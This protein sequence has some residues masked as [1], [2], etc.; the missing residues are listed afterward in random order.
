MCC[1]AQKDNRNNALTWQSTSCSGDISIPCPGQGINPTCADYVPGF[2]GFP[3]IP[4]I[5]VFVGGTVKQNGLCFEPTLNSGAST[6]LLTLAS[7]MAGKTD[8]LFV[9]DANTREIKQQGRC[10]DVLG[11]NAYATAQLTS[12]TRS[13]R[14]NWFYSKESKQLTSGSRSGGL[15]LTTGANPTLIGAVG[16]IACNGSPN[17]E[18]V[19]GADVLLPPPLRTRWCNYDLG[20]QDGGSLAFSD[21][22][23]SSSADGTPASDGRLNNAKAWCSGRNGQNGFLQVNLPEAKIITAI[24]VQGYAD[25]MGKHYFVKTF[26][27]TTSYD[28]TNFIDYPLNLSTNLVDGKETRLVDLRPPVAGTFIRIV[29]VSSVGNA[30]IRVEFRGC[31]DYRGSQG[32]QGATGATGPSN[33][34]GQQGQV[35]RVGDQGPKGDVGSKGEL[36]PIGEQGAQGIPGSKGQQG[37]PG[38]AGAAGTGGPSGDPGVEGDKGSAGIRGSTGPQGRTGMTGPSGAPGIEGATGIDGVPG[39]QGPRGKDG[40]EG[41]DGHNGLPGPRGLPGNPGVTGDKGPKGPQGPPGEQG[42]MGRNGLDG[43]SGPPGVDGTPDS[44]AVLTRA[45]NLLDLVSSLEKKFKKYKCSLK[46]YRS[47]PDCAT[48]APEAPIDQAATKVEKVLALDLIKEHL[49]E[50]LRS[51]HTEDLAKKSAMTPEEDE[52]EFHALLAARRK[53]VRDQAKKAEKSAGSSKMSWRVNE[54]YILGGCE[55]CCQTQSCIGDC[56][57]VAPS[58]SSASSSNPSPSSLDSSSSSSL[59]SSKSSLLSPASSSSLSSLRTVVVKTSPGESAPP[60]G[61]Q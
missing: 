21:F 34:K 49:K 60:G 16:L 61:N 40:M 9:F 11:S 54:K 20:V 37:K 42:R 51:A 32:T 12:C 6:N 44:P 25:S 59:S 47:H 24:A 7:C 46:S 43:P 4:Q 2:P 3:D 23:S 45:Q 26:M 36:G 56:N 17:Q 15:C 39:P 38:D 31:V 30:C 1:Q 22:T 52:G 18:F 41:K 50:L 10:L 8:Q 57:C 27:I 5:D 35:G 48:G 58:A 29:P 28:N 53:R 13:N 14:Q 55:R 19:F 33:E